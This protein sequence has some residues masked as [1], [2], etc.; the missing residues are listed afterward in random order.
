PSGGATLGSIASATISIE[1][2]MTEDFPAL[3]EI[4]SGDQQSGF[5]GDM[6]EPF[7]LSV[8]E[9]GDLAAARD[10][11]WRV[12]PAGAG[13]LIDGQV[14]RSDDAGLA[15]NS[16]EILEGGVITVI[17][18][19]GEQSVA[20]RADDDTP[21]TVRFTVN[22]GFAGTADLT[23]NQR[24]VGGALDKACLALENKTERSAAEADLLATCDKL[25]AGTAG[26]IKSGLNRLQPEE[27]FAIG[28]LS[29]DTA[30]L[31]VTN[32][33][34]RINA[35]RL[36][37]HG[38]D[39]SG[40]ELQLYG[41]TIPGY[42]SN[43]ILDAVNGGGAGDDEGEPS[44]FGA[45]VN[46]TVSVG[47]LDRSDREM[48]LDFDNQ[49]VTAGVDY[50]INDSVVVGGSLGVTRHQGD[51]SS[52]GGG[53]ELKST[54]LSAFATWYDED[55]IYVD[56]ILHYGS[57]KFDIERRINLD[58]EAAQFARGKP[59]ATEFA[60]SLG[61]GLEYASGS[62]TYG[63]YGRLS[64]SSVDVDAYD[65]SAS[66]PQSPG[67]GSVLSVRSQSIDSSSIVLGGHV[68]RAISTAGGV[69]LPQ[70]RLELEHRFSDSAREVEAS[71]RYDPEKNLFAIDSENVDTDYL[72]L[73]LGGSAVFRNGRSAFVFY[74]TRLGQDRLTQNWFKV[75][76][77]FEF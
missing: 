66:D 53:I 36:G 57:S 24:A 14:T 64:F 31:Q 50:R 41:Q 6:L 27:V 61:A 49:S 39:L 2:E 54:S 5:P 59:D 23:P 22:A 45:F 10:V 4:I 30:D 13:R 26:D 55:D 11:S 44:R 77:R 72:N 58:G 15:R 75:G 37:S 60:L 18:T 71:F 34:S 17:A 8:K 19:V 48:G 67:F 74:E 56:A 32:V 33:Q 21:N 40:L 65:E 20:S 47:K 7:V 42:V 63:P 46:G 73:G 69:Y 76:V 9:Q 52:E 51:Y 28:T 38:F 3:L 25:Q 29:L 43:A 70:A 35:I 1:D 68:S 16:L 12:E 62:W